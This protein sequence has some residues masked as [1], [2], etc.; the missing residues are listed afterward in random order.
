[1]YFLW[2]TGESYHQTLI[3]NPCPAEPWYSLHLQT[4]QIQISWLL[5]AIKYLNLYKQS[6]INSLI[7]WQLE[8]GIISLFIQHDKG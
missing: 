5:F 4:V 6:G 8:V 1:M 3:F 2:R 7:G